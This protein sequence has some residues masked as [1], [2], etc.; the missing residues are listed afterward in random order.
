MN[1]NRIAF[2]RRDA[3]DPPK[4]RRFMMVFKFIAKI[5][6]HHQ[7]AFSPKSLDDSCPPAKSPFITAK[8][9]KFSF[10]KGINAFPSTRLL[11]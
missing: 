9:R 1:E 7:A 6:I 2:M 8:P 11:H 10:G 5:V 4:T 3:Q